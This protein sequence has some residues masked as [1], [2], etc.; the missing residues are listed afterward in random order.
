M[1]ID[2]EATSQRRQELDRHRAD[3]DLWV[4]LYGQVYDLTELGSLDHPGS[5]V[6]LD[7][8]NL[9]FWKLE[10]G[11]TMKTRDVYYHVKVEPPRS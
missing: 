6:G 4:A 9:G 11:K 7:H 10:K 2:W 8:H 1:L 5:L 3:G